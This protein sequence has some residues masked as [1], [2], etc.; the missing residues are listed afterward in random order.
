MAFPR[1]IAW[2]V[3]P[4]RRHPQAR[5]RASSREPIVSLA[6][7]G[8]SEHRRQPQPPESGTHC[9]DW[10]GHV[11]R[12]DEAVKANHVAIGRQLDCCAAIE[13][14][15]VQLETGGGAAG[16]GAGARGRRRWTIRSVLG[17]LD[18]NGTLGGRA[19][20]SV[21]C[22][23]RL[24]VSHRWGRFGPP[25]LTHSIVSKGLRRYTCRTRP[26]MAGHL[27]RMEV[28]HHGGQPGRMLGL[29]HQELDD[30]I[31]TLAIFRLARQLGRQ[32]KNALALVAGRSLKVPELG[33]GVARQVDLQLVQIARA[34][35]PRSQLELGP[36][37]CHLD[38]PGLG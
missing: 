15:Q 7:D 13:K 33:R 17:S 24:R 16:F 23:L 37:C 12:R 35:K 28:L 11:G 27:P 5:R 21:I 20:G 25:R 34:V 32:L 31:A 2:A 10:T 19:S 29:E 14:L 30:R 9:A 6:L 36:M 3:G 4:S 26:R 1:R 8:V 18:G 38:R 22:H